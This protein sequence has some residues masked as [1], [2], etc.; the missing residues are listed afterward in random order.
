MTLRGGLST[1]STS[2]DECALVAAVPRSPGEFCQAATKWL[3]QVKLLGAYT[4]PYGIQAAGTL[5]SSAGPERRATWL[6][7]ASSTDL[8]R[9]LFNGTQRM[10]ILEP[11][12]TYGDRINVF[13]LRLTKLLSIGGQARMRAMIDFYN[14][15]NSNAA[16]IEDTRLEQNFAPAAIVN[17]RLV[18]F[19][20]QFDF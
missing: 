1:G 2:T 7:D 3:T 5:R 8:G 14:L 4:F 9:P 11:G 18:K 20:V 17:G 19:G 10:N 16:I 13:D 6:H 15:F 12:T